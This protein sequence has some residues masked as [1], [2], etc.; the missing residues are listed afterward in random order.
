M[1][2]AAYLHS[3]C[4]SL[5]VVVV[6]QVGHKGGVVRQILAHSQSDGLAAELAVAP[7]GLQVNGQSW[8]QHEE[9]QEDGYEAQRQSSR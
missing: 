6:Q 2:E 4:S 5:L 9:Q 8:G 7:Q 1:W 3:Q